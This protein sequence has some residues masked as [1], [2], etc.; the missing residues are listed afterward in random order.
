MAAFALVYFKTARK[1]RGTSMQIFDWRPP[2]FLA[3][4]N[5]ANGLRHI[6]PLVINTQVARQSGTA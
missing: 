2:E 1:L 6:A 5:I 3:R 4:L